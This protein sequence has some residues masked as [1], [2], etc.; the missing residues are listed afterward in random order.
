MKL[1]AVLRALVVVVWATSSHGQVDSTGTDTSTTTSITV[2]ESSLTTTA[3]SVA[4]VTATS[5]TTNSVLLTSTSTSS[6]SSAEVTET[7]TSLIISTATATASS[8]LSTVTS[9][10]DVTATSTTTNSV[11]LTSTSTSSLSSA[12]A[13][14]TSTS[15]IIS[16]VTA[17]ESSA[18]RT[19][20]SGVDATAT[21]SAT[22]SAIL[23]STS[24]ISVSSASFT[25]PSTSSTSLTTAATSSSITPT[26]TSAT[27]VTT[28]SAKD[29]AE[30]TSASTSSLFSAASTEAAISSSLLSAATPSGT[31][32]AS[33]STLIS[34]AEEVT[35]SASTT[36]GTAPTTT[37]SSSPT[38]GADGA[39][40]L[41]PSSEKTTAT[42]APTV[43]STLYSIT[44]TVASLA[45]QSTDSDSSTSVAV[46][47]P[48]VSESS[49]AIGTVTS[50][51]TSV[52][53]TSSTSSIQGSKTNSV[54]PT[55]TSTKVD[56]TK[57]TSSQTRYYYPV[58]PYYKAFTS[59][60]KEAINI[61]W[62]AAYPRQSFSDLSKPYAY[63]I[64]CQGDSDKYGCFPLTVFEDSNPCSI[65][66]DG[67]Q[68]D[69]TC[70]LPPMQRTNSCYS[71]QAVSS[72]YQVRLEEDDTNQDIPVDYPTTYQSG[73][74]T[75]C[76]RIENGI[77]V[78][79]QCTHYDNNFDDNAGSMNINAANSSSTQS[80]SAPPTHYEDCSTFIDGIFIPKM[81]KTGGSESL[82]SS[83]VPSWS[84]SSFK[85]DC[86][87][88]VNGTYV[89][90]LTCTGYNPG[91]SQ[92]QYE[93]KYPCGGTEDGSRNSSICVGFSPEPL[94]NYTFSCPVFEEGRYQDG[95][96]I[97]S[98]YTDH[99]CTGY[100]TR[101]QPI[102]YRM[103]GLNFSC[104]DVIAGLPIERQCTFYKAIPQLIPDFQRE[105]PRGFSMDANNQLRKR[106]DPQNGTD[107][108]PTPTRTISTTG[109]TPTSVPDYRNWYSW[110]YPCPETSP[111]YYVNGTLG[112]TVLNPS[113]CT[114]SFWWSQRTVQPFY[115][116]AQITAA[117]PQYYN[118]SIVQDEKVAEGW[119]DEICVF[120]YDLPVLGAY[121]DHPW[122]SD[123]SFNGQYTSGRPCERTVDAWV[124][125]TFV[126]NATEV[127]SVCSTYVSPWYSSAAKVDLNSFKY[128]QEDFNVPCDTLIAIWVNGIF[129]GMETRTVTCRWNS[130][131]YPTYNMTSKIYN[132]ATAT[133]NRY[134]DV[135]FPCNTSRT[136]PSNI[137]ATSRICS[138]PLN[139][140]RLYEKGSTARQY[141]CRKQ[142]TVSYNGTQT[143][144]TFDTICTEVLTEYGYDVTTYPKPCQV[145]DGYYNDQIYEY[146][147]R[148]STCIGREST[149]DYVGTQYPCSR[150]IAQTVN[151][152]FL[153]MAKK[154]VTCT[155]YANQRN[156]TYDQVNYECEWER[157]SGNVTIYGTMNCNEY[158][159]QQ[160][161]ALSKV[162]YPCQQ[163]VQGNWTWTGDILRYDYNTLTNTTCTRTE[164]TDRYGNN[165]TTIEYPYLC[166]QG[167]YICDG[168][169]C[170]TV[171]ASNTCTSRS[172]YYSYGSNNNYP[173]YPEYFATVS[174]YDCQRNVT[175]Y[176]NGTTEMAATVN[177]TCTTTSLGNWTLYTTWTYPCRSQTTSRS[178]TTSE[179]IDGTAAA[180]T[181][182][183]FILTYRNATQTEFVYP[184]QVGTSNLTYVAMCAGSAPDGSVGSSGTY[185]CNYVHPDGRVYPSL[186]TAYGT[187]REVEEASCSSSPWPDSDYPALYKW[188]SP[189]FLSEPQRFAN[190]SF[191]YPQEWFDLGVSQSL[192]PPKLTV[193]NGSF[194]FN[195]Q[196]YDAE[197]IYWEGP[198]WPEVQ[199]QSGSIPVYMTDLP[200]L[201]I[202]VDQ[203][204]NGTR[205]WENFPYPPNDPIPLARGP[206]GLT[207]GNGMLPLEVWP[208]VPR[209]NNGD[210]TNT[211]TPW[212]LYPLTD[213]RPNVTIP[214][215]NIPPP[216]IDPCPRPPSNGSMIFS[217]AGLV[218]RNTTGYQPGGAGQVSLDVGSFDCQYQ[219]TLVFWSIDAPSRNVADPR[220]AQPGE[221]ATASFSYNFQSGALKP[222]AHNLTGRALFLDANKNIVGDFTVTGSFSVISPVFTAALKMQDSNITAAL[223]FALD[224]TTSV[225]GLDPCYFARYL[226]ASAYQRC[227][228][229]NPGVAANTDRILVFF[230][231]K[232]RVG[233]GACVFPL[234]QQTATREQM[235]NGSRISTA[236]FQAVE[237]VPNS[238]SGLQIITDTPLF[239]IPKAALV[240][241]DYLWSAQILHSGYDLSL[242]SSAVNTRVKIT[243]Y[244]LNIKSIALGGNTATFIGS[245][246]VSINAVVVTNSETVT[247][248]WQLQD[249]AGA[250][251][252]LSTISRTVGTS[253]FRIDTSSLTD[254]TYTVTLVVEDN[255]SNTARAIVTFAILKS[256]P[257]PTGCSISPVSGEEL[258]TAFTVNCVDQL[259]EG[260]LYYYTYLRS[261]VETLVAYP[262][263]AS[264]SIRLPAGPSSAN[265]LI[266]VQVRAYIPS[267]LYVSAPLSLNVT[268]SAAVVA[269]ADVGSK[270]ATL[271]TEA[272]SSGSA[273][274]AAVDSF[275]S[276]LSTLSQDEQRTA[277]AQVAN[278]ISA[279]VNITTETAAS[280][281]AKTEALAKMVTAG[282]TDTAAR[283]A[284]SKA[285][286]Q[287]AQFLATSSPP[288]STLASAAAAILGSADTTRSDSGDRVLQTMFY[289]GAALGNSLSPGENAS[290][291]VPGS[292]LDVMSAT[293]D[294]IP[295]GI[296][297]SGR[298][299]LFRRDSTDSCESIFGEAVTDT[300]SATTDSSS[301]VAIQ[302]NCLDIPPYP[303]NPSTLLT[304]TQ[305]YVNNTKLHV[306]S[307]FWILILSSRLVPKALS[308][309]VTVGGQPYTGRLAKNITVTIPFTFT[310][311]PQRRRRSLFARRQAPVYE[312]QCV[313][314]D[315][316][317]KEWE[318]SRCTVSGS[319]GSDS[320][321]CSCDALGAVSVRLTTTLS[322]TPTTATST[323]TGTP[324]PT[325]AGDG[326]PLDKD[327]SKLSTGAIVGIAVGGAAGVALIAGVAFFFV[328][329]R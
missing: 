137:W 17:T 241:G 31:V 317:S 316:E 244:Y 142:T 274:T 211:T 269:A 8:A 97:P 53:T 272:D 175:N 130:Y 67:T 213:I 38:A 183:G 141:P 146:Y 238:S 247:P 10:A 242:A 46:A 163:R 283:D 59:D 47:S 52:T 193:S 304:D 290:L 80:P 234:L 28:T 143:L 88:F 34:S 41:S 93:Y 77:Y 216:F 276:K 288:K 197:G 128:R 40:S 30:L 169:S 171:H 326:V 327:E 9:A 282:V 302:A 16:S 196:Y 277:K 259:F 20:T 101:L 254:G 202:F 7:S 287:L 314:Y 99:N 214:G 63:P 268:S 42:S 32:T 179:A 164:Q 60:G 148:G 98:H 309:G 45:S 266:S 43:S 135:Q 172:S 116:R 120:T 14:E 275:T 82:P 253:G 166:K 321:Q 324:S 13:T 22:N 307:C 19:V 320:V 177:T 71:A 198:F 185:P 4:D 325:D 159:S 105:P 200:S 57:P 167:T 39:T 289:V 58:Y 271:F 21:S 79:R 1:T 315:S 237:I 299:T 25:E 222:G 109:P 156:Q 319:A 48:T 36:I 262:G 91:P 96:W 261:G 256:L 303:I 279:S 6:L 294:S 221:V 122:G 139:E 295:K 182:T 161:S 94:Y 144:L 86:S 212:L 150:W 123:D 157:R 323:T 104:P 329:K 54:P 121:D 201:P 160:T 184:C 251:V 233:G 85:Y 173:Q 191:A 278:A 313:W 62:T 232:N 263:A 293:K 194:Y 127:S 203:R 210:W 297:K 151:G 87:A 112:P 44:T 181:C 23:T 68:Y 207:T 111:G 285:V 195:Q 108:S 243:Q 24:A 136:D 178:L 56:D 305:K 129:H 298:G 83:R 76:S 281:T 100:M 273:T 81:C 296:G 11:L 267:T 174:V 229:N 246:T 124:D 132:I 306:F 228:A 162:E 257:A 113:N 217:G 192:S 70:A 2:T 218:Q 168:M 27:E 270:Y 147:T 188:L 145:S 131:T 230:N 118:T 33:V 106:A 187:A 286:A 312:P 165:I 107:I 225:D 215:T 322:E 186:C 117:C 300:I 219:S 258:T 180:T 176:F 227:K 231:C 158:L 49:L 204:G 209:P 190:G 155:H 284:T 73:Y 103:E 78:E 236:S 75:N 90:P 189:G 245:T 138:F 66:I 255:H 311:I 35:G 50:A 55:P 153:G 152:T 51:D 114:S 199:N 92:P 64:A 260:A 264:Q 239:V 3:T 133:T 206:G 65:N 249:S 308:L 301:V 72:N 69:G 140:Q 265:N 37:T 250:S 240:E 84:P 224:A 102:T 328:K 291:I 115:H 205:P 154:N 149:Y 310:Y 61:T 89:S 15:L 18:L 29:S 226:S 220:L 252:A 110:V 292:R 318:P 248:K 126:V 170:Y 235:I 74:I 134:V 280:A 5:T 26:V 223:D 208:L 95:V 12:E 119:R 125:G